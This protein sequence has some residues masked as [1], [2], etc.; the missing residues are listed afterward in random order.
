MV[1]W[2]ADL[3]ILPIDKNTYVSGETKFT[4]DPFPCLYHINYVLEPGLTREP[5]EGSQDLFSP[6]KSNPIQTWYCY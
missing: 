6:F 5:S 4:G 2:A 3:K 1:C